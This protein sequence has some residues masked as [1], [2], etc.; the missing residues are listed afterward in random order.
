M[1]TSSPREIYLDANATTPVMSVAAKEAQDAMEELYGN[2][3][4]SHITGLRA[5][6]I[7]ESARTAARTIL[8]APTGRIV[9][10]SGAT[11]AIQTGIFSVLCQI[12]KQ[13]EQHPEQ[14]SERVLLYGATEHKA[15]PQALQ[16]WN[17]ML[18]IK[19]QVLEI[20]VDEHGLLDLEFLRA[21][22]D[23]AD[24][25]CTM[26]VNNE[27]GV[28]HDLSAIEK[29]V[30]SSER[31]IPWLVDCVQ[32][33]AKIDLNL[34]EL[35]IDYAPLS[36][37][38]LYAPKGIG[39]LYVRD[40]SPLTPLIAGGGQEGGAR[41]GTENLPGV[42]AIAA[43]L[44][45]LEAQNRDIF[46]DHATLVQFRDRLIASLTKAFPKIVFNTPFEHAVPTTV[47]FAVPGIS[48]KEILDLFDAAS[49]R[50]SS[51]SACGSAIQGSYVLEA[52][53]LPKWQSDGAIRVSFGPA[54]TESEINAA[55]RRIEEAGRAMCD[56]C[57]IVSHDVDTTTGT[58]LDGLIQL[59]KGS[60]CSW[61]FMDA[62]S[63]Q[64]IIID[65]FDELVDRIESIVH[66]QESRVLAV[67]DT[68]QHV[69][70][71]SPRALMVKALGSRMVMP[72][73]PTDILGWPTAPHGTVTLGDGTSA[74]FLQLSAST[75][76]AKTEL[77]GHTVDGQAFLLGSLE[78]DRQ[79]AAENVRFAFTGD[80]LLIG[81]IGRTDFPSSCAEGM[82]ASLRR[83][84]TIL[85][86]R[87]IL[88]PTHDYS[89][90]FCTSFGTERK[91]NCFLSRIVDPVVELPMADYLSEKIRVDGEINDDTNCELVC[92]RISTHVE[93]KSS[94]DI[95]PD[96]LPD[97]FRQHAGSRIID[98][99]EPHEFKFAQDWNALGL[100]APPLNV[101]LTR[102]TDFLQALATGEQS[103]DAD[104]IFICRSGN[105]SSKAAEATRRLG[106][107]NAW[108]ISGGIA[109]GT[110][111]SSSIDEMEYSI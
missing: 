49:I 29:V 22:I 45:E 9:F 4:S 83:L 37:H 90:G 41:G 1:S 10:T 34:S 28:I 97:F 77:P 2:P 95:G 23:S 8:N 75:I 84:P 7:L 30:R 57:L 15:V 101:P 24:I 70:H 52:M 20:P 50:V 66:C 82:Y 43:V 62:A 5:R 67:L 76:L 107:E 88:C 27:T 96:E 102:L 92:G 74:P 85:S 36:G 98:V 93:D 55:C 111:R 56:A 25:V 72:D 35:S 79:L 21:H 89:N 99:R 86:D 109:L 26:A 73:Q 108:H 104:M 91:Q 47:N 71:D 40:E 48:S 14:A 46:R 17:E 61:L 69:D 53:G 106:Y 6:F 39:I 100:A 103:S 54:S 60:M 78:K 51:G 87:T 65:P 32:A 80:T 33:I 38:K 42:A 94:I 68:H 13:R 59:K 58:Q 105:R 31:H 63:K 64:C 44:R 3:S 11:E 12:R 18:G 19:N 110:S 16:H 81:G